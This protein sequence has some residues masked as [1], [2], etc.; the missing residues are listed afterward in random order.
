MD[1]ARKKV[2]VS[3]YPPGADGNLSLYIARM[4]P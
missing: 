3:G 1:R 4:A 2:S